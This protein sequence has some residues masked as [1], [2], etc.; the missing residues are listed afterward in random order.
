MLLTMPQYSNLSSDRMMACRVFDGEIRKIRSSYGP[1]HPD[2]D[3]FQVIAKYLE[4]RIDSMRN[5]GHY[6]ESN[7]SILSKG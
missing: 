2:Y 6:A 5:K 7:N 3:K 4:E 1:E